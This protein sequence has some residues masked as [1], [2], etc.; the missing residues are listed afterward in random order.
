M[1]SSKAGRAG[2]PPARLRARSRRALRFRRSLGGGTSGPRRRNRVS[3]GSVCVEAEGPGP[4]A[5]EERAG[6]GREEERPGRARGRRGRSGEGQ[7]AGRLGSRVR[8]GACHRPG[9]VE[10]AR[11]GRPEHAARPGSLVSAACELEALRVAAAACL[12]HWRPPMACTGGGEA[13][14]AGRPRVGRGFSWVFW[15][16][17]LCLGFPGV[18]AAAGLFSYFFIRRPRLLFPKKKRSLFLSQRV[19]QAQSWKSGAVLDAGAAAGPAFP[20]GASSQGFE[21]CRLVGVYFIWC[22]M[23]S[24][25]SSVLGGEQVH[26]GVMGLILVL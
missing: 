14:V 19:A 13:G 15:P 16:L 10:G 21:A 8:A 18:S 4:S 9:P 11:A 2:A 24:A 5:G 23:P 20:E 12:S 6:E 7:D 1:G 3:S 25:S 22:W 17:S 26:L